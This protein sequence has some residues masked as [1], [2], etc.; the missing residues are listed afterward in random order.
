MKTEKAAYKANGP[1]YSI[2]STIG[3]E[4]GPSLPQSAS[5]AILKRHQGRRVAD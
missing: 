5:A 1:F 2:V 3:L 4:A